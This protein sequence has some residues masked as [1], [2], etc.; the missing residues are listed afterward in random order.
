MADDNLNKNKGTSGNTQKPQ[1]IGKGI[2]QKAGS[3]YLQSK[4]VPKGLADKAVS[5]AINKKGG[6]LKPKIGLGGPL[7]G[8]LGGAFKGKADVDADIPIEQQSTFGG[9]VKFWEFLK[10]PMALLPLLFGGFLV[11]FVFLILV[12]VMIIEGESGSF[13]NAPGYSSIVGGSY[14]TNITLTGTS[15]TYTL[16]EYVARVTKAELGNAGTE[17][18]KAQAVLARTFVLNHTKIGKCQIENSPDFQVVNTDAEID[19]KYYEAAKATEGLVLTA[20]GKITDA[21][22]ASYPDGTEHGWT[23][24]K[25][26]E[27]TCSSG[28]CTT[29]L[30]KYPSGTAWD[31]TMTNSDQWNGS[32]LDNQSG[33]CY[34]VSQLGILYYESIGENYDA[35]LAHFYDADVEISKLYTA[36]SGPEVLSGTGQF[37]GN[38][39]YYDQ[40]DYANVAFCGRKTYSDSEMHYCNNTGNTICSSGCGATSTAIIMASLFQDSSIDPIA[41][42]NKFA[43]SNGVACSA[44]SFGTNDAAYPYIA[45]EYKVYYKDVEKSNL[46][47]AKAAFDRGDVLAIISVGEGTFTSKGHIMTIV[48]YKDDKFFILDPYGGDGTTPT[49]NNACGND[50]DDTRNGYCAKDVI[51]QQMGDKFKLFSRNSLDTIAECK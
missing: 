15:T 34:G 35:I 48:G 47:C 41:I 43:A 26:S 5:N 14:C 2:A 49:R 50:G 30:Y 45:K 11:L 13:G 36:G 19:E 12:V 23:A 46:D 24:G 40:N 37:N 20:G 7:K 4:G 31:F 22:F 38:L 8:T 29:T 28:M 17:G 6:F 39:I 9:A 3:A 16:E 1:G 42:N 32:Y 51:L 25:C 27:V 44:T 10:D 21:F 18:L 33:H